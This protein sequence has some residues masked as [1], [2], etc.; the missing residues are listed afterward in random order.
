MAQVLAMCAYIYIV[1]NN[2]TD[3][4]NIRSHVHVHCMFNY[5]YIYLS[6]ERS[7]IKKERLLSC[8]AFTHMYIVHR[9][10]IRT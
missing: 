8:Y 6:C 7:I 1:L 10:A 5:M 3:I 2:D 9:M 4:Y